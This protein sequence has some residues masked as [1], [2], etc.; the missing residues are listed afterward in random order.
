MKYTNDSVEHSYKSKASTQIV[1]PKGEFKYNVQMY[2][3]E[4]NTK[5]HDINLD[6]NKDDI[7]LDELKLNEFKH[8]LDD[9]LLKLNEKIN[10]LEINYLNNK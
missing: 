7:N 10:F 3:K 6:L 2:E 1:L 5:C 4:L 9:Y 8:I